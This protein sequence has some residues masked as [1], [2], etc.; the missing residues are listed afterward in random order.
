MA[1]S[2][3]TQ[4]LSD[5]KDAV[6]GRRIETFFERGYE[7]KNQMRVTYNKIQ[8]IQAFTEWLEMKA[9]EETCGL[10][11]GQIPMAIGG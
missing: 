9:S 11:S 1:F 7:N 2:T 3:W 6:A 8:D 4:I 10:S 5:W